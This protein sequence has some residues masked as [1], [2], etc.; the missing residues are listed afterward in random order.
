MSL[1]R[2]FKTEFINVDF[3]E[4]LSSVCNTA[5]LSKK[6]LLD[7]TA[8]KLNYITSTND[9]FLAVKQ[10]LDN[11]T[12]FKSICKKTG[13]TLYSYT[14]YERDNKTYK[15]VIQTQRVLFNNFIDFI[16]KIPILES[17]MSR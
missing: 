3:D 10:T 6:H 15:T 1:I 4:I 13:D 14:N 11:M 9:N 17:K 12:D 16:K 2:A 8:Y 7:Y 5:T